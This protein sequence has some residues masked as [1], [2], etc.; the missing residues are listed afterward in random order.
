MSFITSGRKMWLDLIVF[1][2]KELA[3]DR[4]YYFQKRGQEFQREIAK[5]LANRHLLEGVKREPLTAAQAKQLVVRLA[6]AVILMGILVLA[7]IV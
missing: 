7:F 4:N 1:D 3:M 2:K 5:E 6:P